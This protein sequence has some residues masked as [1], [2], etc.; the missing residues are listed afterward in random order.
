MASRKM[1]FVLPQDLAAQLIRRVPAQERSRYVAHAL[2]ARMAGREEE[3]IRACEIANRDSEVT[4]I[5][6]ELDGLTD[7]IAEPWDHAPAR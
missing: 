3:L 1:T 2:A 7:E 6:R 4:S 5:E